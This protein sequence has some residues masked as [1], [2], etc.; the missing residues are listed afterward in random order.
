VLLIAGL[1][2]WAFNRHVTPLVEHAEEQL[3][4]LRQEVTNNRLV[5]L[6]L[7]ALQELYN[8]VDDELSQ[9]QILELR[10]NVVQRFAA[11]PAAAAGELAR[12]T[13]S[14]DARSVIE[15]EALDTAQRRVGRLDEM[16]KD[17]FETAIL[18]VSHPSWYL[19][20]T[21]SF[22]NNNNTRNQGLAFN[23]ALY[24]MHVRDAS[25]AIEILDE[26]RKAPE[27]EAGPKRSRLLFALSRLQYQAFQ[28]EKDAAYFR[29][30]LQY[31]QQSVREDA[32]HQQP[33]VFLEYLLSIDRKSASVDM[34]PMEG[35]G[36]GEGEGERGAIVTDP[37]D[38]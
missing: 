17:H 11:N 38:F 26:L 32:D 19:Q 27:F 16:Y 1:Q 15:Q 34:S 12:V 36:T 6:S 24:L 8:T 21:A 7:E 30:A 4:A 23:H 14:L 37:E 29:E 9:R 13:S 2:A 31:V 10:D 28:L 35:E 5:N 33:K 25:G 18:A 22:L 20:P 3:S